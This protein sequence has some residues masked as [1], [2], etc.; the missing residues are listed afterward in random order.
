LLESV[1]GCLKVIVVLNQDWDSALNCFVHCLTPPLILTQKVKGAFI[2]WL[3][4]TA[5]CAQL[6]WQK[7]CCPESMGLTEPI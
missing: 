7:M 2:C 4:P 5:P 1:Q 6:L 3:K